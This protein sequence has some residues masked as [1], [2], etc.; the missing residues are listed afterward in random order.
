MK[1]AFHGLLV[2]LCFSHVRARTSCFLPVAATSS[3]DN[4]CG[5]MQS[6]G[7]TFTEGGSFG[8][9]RVGIGEVIFGYDEFAHDCAAPAVPLPACGPAPAP[10]GG[11]LN[12]PADV[13]TTETS[14]DVAIQFPDGR[15]PVKAV[16][17]NQ[18]GAA[19]N[20]LS[21]CSQGEPT[22][23]CLTSTSPLFTLS[24]VQSMVHESD[25]GSKQHA[26]LDGYL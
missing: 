10:A 14:S 3:V 21:S 7:A 13:Q 18:F 8:G 6:G 24:C 16:P 26:V 12:D 9:A 5:L 2:Q 23:I 1:V 4:F 22:T 19:V 17:C 20:P 15:V 11:I 25:D